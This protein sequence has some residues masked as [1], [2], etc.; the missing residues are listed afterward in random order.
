MNFLEYDFIMMFEKYNFY[1]SDEFAQKGQVILFE[2]NFIISI[3]NQ[4]CID[5]A[6]LEYSIKENNVVCLSLYF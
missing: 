6:I 5:F 1:I 4:S 2:G 3:E